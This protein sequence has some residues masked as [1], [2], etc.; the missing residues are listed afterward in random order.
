[1]AGT[2]SIGFLE[3]HAFDSRAEKDTVTAKEK[4]LGYLV[5]PIGP[6]LV[7]AVL[8]SY[9]NVYY[10]DTLGLTLVWGGLFLLIFPILSKIANAVV[11]LWVG[12]LIERTHTRQGKARPYLFICAPLF[13]VTCGLCF[14]VPSLGIGPEIVWV[15]ISYNLFYLCAN[16]LYSM[17]HNLMVPLSTRDSEAR[18]SLSVMNNVAMTMATGIIIAMLFP[19]F[20]LPYLGASREAWA[21]MGWILGAVALP[22]ILM[23]YYFTRER[24]T[25]EQGEDAQAEPMAFREQIRTV[26]TDRYWVTLMVYLFIYTLSTNFKNL[27]LLY[28]C[29]YVLGSYNDGITLTLVNVI[30]GIPMGLGIFAVWPI[31]KRAG[32]RNTTLWGFVVVAV[33]SAICALFPTNMPIVLV[34]QFI[35]NIGC[36]PA[37]YVFMALFAD[38]LDHCEW[39]FGFRCDGLSSA[40]YSIIQTVCVG[41]ANGVFNLMLGIT[42]YVPP[43]VVDGVT[44]AAAQSDATRNVFIFFFLILDVIASAVIVFLLSKLDVE[45]TIGAEQE[46]I[47]ARHAAGADTSGNAKEQQ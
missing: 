47:K 34:G 32:L 7:N 3:G 43:S 29:N 46:E 14:S 19:M 33:G 41:I 11:N 44:V 31:A 12:K 36:L 17:A 4:I 13:F 35:K 9:L 28:Y 38:V 21:A 45:K 40:I 6:A 24:V 25:E 10:T 22:L 26:A 37:S 23:E 8:A 30:G 39:R 15:T 1:M 2:V 5:G 16:S 42:G 20:V 27:S 18:G